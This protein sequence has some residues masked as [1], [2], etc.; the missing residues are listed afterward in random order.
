MTDPG[1]AANCRQ[2][3]YRLLPDSTSKARQLFDLAVAGRFTWNHFLSKP[4]FLDKRLLH[5]DFL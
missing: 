5:G 2:V 3:R 1:T 4:Q